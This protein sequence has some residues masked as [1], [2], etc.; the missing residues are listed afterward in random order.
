MADMLLWLR[1]S[2]LLRL[3]PVTF[4]LEKSEEMDFC[5]AIENNSSLVSLNKNLFIFAYVCDVCLY[6][7]YTHVFKVYGHV[8]VWRLAL[9]VLLGG[10][11]PCVLRKYLLLNTDFSTTLVSQHASELNP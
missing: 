10:S 9:D 7:W 11:P 8:C 2:A 3:G 5:M 1:S 4:K 6:E